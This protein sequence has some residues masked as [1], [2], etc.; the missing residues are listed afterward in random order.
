MGGFAPDTVVRSW[1]PAWRMPR[2]PPRHSRRPSSVRP[3]PRWPRGG[4]APT[5][6]VNVESTWCHVP[7]PMLGSKGGYGPNTE[8]KE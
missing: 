7:P 4:F 3:G 2:G 8:A 5:P 1:K 6:F